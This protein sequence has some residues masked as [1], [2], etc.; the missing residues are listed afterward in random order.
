MNHFLPDDSL[1]DPKRKSGHPI[2][3]ERNETSSP[4]NADCDA[5]D[6]ISGPV[7]TSRVAECRPGEPENATKFS[8]DCDHLPCNHSS[9]A[10][11]D[12]DDNLYLSVQPSPKNAW[13]SLSIGLPHL[14]R[15]IGA[16]DFDF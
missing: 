7:N 4:E 10:N 2:L 16:M 11:N 8:S 15:P 13:P 12:G 14:V 1:H 9:H 3:T 5:N 6:E